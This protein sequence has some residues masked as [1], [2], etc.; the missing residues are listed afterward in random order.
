[1][2]DLARYVWEYSRALLTTPENA[3]LL[4]VSWVCVEAVAPIAAFVVALPGWSGRQRLMIY[5][6]L[7]A[8]KNFAAVFW[9]S[10]LVWIPHAQPALCAA[11][12]GHPPCQ[13][14][15]ERVATGIVL[16]GALAAGHKLIAPRVRKMIGRPKRHRFVCA[17]CRKIIQIEYTSDPCP[18]CGQTPHEVT[19]RS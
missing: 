19:R 16:G 14:F 1:M 11:T 8:L 2:E 9:C 17:N 3:L 7:G 10:I 4:A 18:A 5:G 15:A 6:L 12:S 13:N